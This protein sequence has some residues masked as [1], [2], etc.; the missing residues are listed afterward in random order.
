VNGLS[1]SNRTIPDISLDASGAS[2]VPIY[3]SPDFGTGTGWVP[4]TIYGTSLACPMTAALVAIAD[5]GRSI[6]GYSLLNSSGGSG[7]SA[8]NP[9]GNSSSLDIHTLLYGFGYSGH[10]FHDITSGSSIGPTSY[11]PL[12]DYDLSTG[13]GSPL[14]TKLDEDLVANTNTVPSWLT[15]AATYN[16]TTRTMFVYGAASIIADPGSAEPTIQ[17][18]GSADV[19]TLNPTSGTDIHIRGISLTGGASAVVT[20]LGVARTL[21]NYHLLVVGVSG[22]T[23]APMFTIDTTSTLDL[24]DNDMAILYGTGSSPLSTVSADLSQAYDGGAW[25]KP[26]LTSSIAKTSSGVTAL[27]YGEASTLGLSTFD[28]LTLGGNAVL[29][30]YTLVGDTNLDGTVNFND[31]SILQNNFSTP[32]NWTSGDFDYNGTINFTDFSLLQN[33]YGKTLASVLT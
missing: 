18:A 13:L 1:S 12:T 6:Y 17:A 23:V 26:G 31:F 3:D 30:K 10:D 19:V 32:G 28:G 27:G 9:N 33:N 24:A 15:G 21:S 29:V 8:S 4:G 20:S 5:Q 14:A 25:N 11:G 2:G 7:V 22:A 16:T